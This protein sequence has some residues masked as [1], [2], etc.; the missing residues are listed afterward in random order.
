M[1]NDELDN[2]RK[3]N[4]S[5][6]ENAFGNQ[7]ENKEDKNKTQPISI[8]KP[9]RWRMIVIGILSVLLLGA[10]GGGLGYMNGIQDR[11]A[12]E[13][14]EA[15]TQAALQFQYGMQQFNAGNY[16]LAKTHFEFVLTTYPEFPG[17][18]EKYT[19]VMVKLAETT[20]KVAQPQITPTPDNREAEE[21][22]NLAVQQVQAQQ[23]AE[24]MNTLE[25][26][27]NADY[28]YRT[29]D[30]DGLYFIT[31][32]YCG[33]NK[34]VIEGDLEEGL[35]LF[36]ILAK[37]APLDR[38]AVNYSSWARLYLTGASFWEVDWEQVVNYFSQLYAAFPNMHDGSGWTVT[39]RFMTG[40]EKYGD[41][42]LEAGDPCGALTHYQ[43]VL[44]ISAI[45]A[46]Q[47][48]YNQAYTRCYPPTATPEPVIA[49]PTPEELPPDEVIEPSAT[50]TEAGQTEE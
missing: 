15:L 27:R 37:Y 23:W 40:S 38:D 21:L 49:T 17:I 45:E 5:G 18:T 32:R 12:R 7:P 3:I 10:A 41:Q 35:Y 29:I 11:I 43:N 22:F 9:K 19:E 28:T 36:S 1:A 26:L 20:G 4:P 39:D 16:E 13:K 47:D 34:M 46:V 42:L 48:K 30:V 6:N 25:A 50:S 24:A 2:T 33:V 44:N 14:E 8:R 31:L